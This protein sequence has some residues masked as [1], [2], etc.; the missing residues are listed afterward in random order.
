MAV[1]ALVLILSFAL[2]ASSQAQTSANSLLSIDQN[3]ATVIDRLVRDWAEPIARVHPDV[4]PT[5]WR[6]VLN[7]LRADQLLVVSLAGTIDG[8]LDVVADSVSRPVTPGSLARTKT[9]GSTAAD[10]TYTPVIPCRLLDTRGIYSPV[11]AGGAFAP[12][13]TRNYAVQGGNGTCLSQLPAGLNPTAIQL[14]VFGMPTTKASGDIEI[15]PQGTTFGTSATMV[16]SGSLEYNTVSTT[17]KVNLANNQIG[18]QVRGGGAN[19]AI[20]VVGYFKAPSA[21]ILPFGSVSLFALDTSSVDSRYAI[22]SSVGTQFSSSLASGGV[23]TIS[24]FGWPASTRH[25]W[26]VVPTTVGGKMQLLSTDIELASNGTYTYYLTVKN[27]SAIATN[28]DLQ[29]YGLD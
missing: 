1:R 27:T 15:L 20:D 24:T 25:V 29:R 16:Y 3:R 18:I 26:R 8:V 19:V 13:E 2:A 7:G 11:Y 4:N 5:Q 23:V 21:P 22:K 12:G 6:E 14:Q 28:Y 9:L 10:V 17:A